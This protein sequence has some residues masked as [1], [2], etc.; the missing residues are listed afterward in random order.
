MSEHSA[1][2]TSKHILSNQ[3]SFNFDNFLEKEFQQYFEQVLDYFIKYHSP[4]QSRFMKTLKCI[5]AKVV[6][7]CLSLLLS[8]AKTVHFERIS[9]EVVARVFSYLLHPD[10]PEQYRTPSVQCFL[11]IL[12]RVNLDHFMRLHEANILL[13]PYV[14]YFSLREEI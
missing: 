3:A 5:N 4:H 12:E 7:D 10:T 11:N 8:K 1:K 13:I 9:L 14:R 2:S 6:I